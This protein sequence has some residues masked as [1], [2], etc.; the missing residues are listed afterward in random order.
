MNSLEQHISY[1]EQRKGKKKRLL[2]EISNMK[3]NI[4]SYKQQKEQIEVSLAILKKIAK[5]TQDEIVFH[6]SNIITMAL[7]SIFEENYEFKLEFIERKNRIESN[8]Y[9]LKNGKKTD[10]LNANGGG[11]VDVISFALRISIWNLVKNRNT[12]ILDEPFK[13]I[14]RDLQVKAG[15]ML[16]LLSE[17]LELQFI[18]IS[19]DKNIIDSADKMFECSINNGI[20]MVEEVA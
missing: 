6:I 2:E 5:Q 3:K 13:Y 1:L 18:I 14:S 20:S 12:I 11:I 16:K 17:K 4:L 8:M 19:H 7:N 10:P 15:K 9:L